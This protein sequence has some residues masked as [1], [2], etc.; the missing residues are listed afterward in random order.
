MSEIDKPPRPTL[1]YE[2]PGGE[3]RRGVSQPLLWL[4]GILAVLFLID[5]LFL[6][7]ISRPR[8]MSNRIKCQSNLRQ[9]GQAIVMYANENHG[10]YPDSFAT[11]LANEDI[12][13]SV[14]V[15]PESN[16]TDATGPTTQAF[17][18]NLTA[19]GHL[20]YIYVGAGW[21]TATTPANAVVAY[22]PLTN[23]GG[24]GMNVLFGDGHVDWL[25]PA[26]AKAI[27]AKAGQGKPPVIVPSGQ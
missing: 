25:T 3:S 7:S 24:T 12:T 19:G 2:S 1:D 13:A 17:V 4:F 21:T 18:T 5:V 11:L 23:H 15:C 14:F 6:P 26:Q 22:E 9:I 20:S 16:D 8:P 27:L 10:A